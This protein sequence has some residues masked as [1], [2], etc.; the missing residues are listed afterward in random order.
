MAGGLAQKIAA[1]IP[2]AQFAVEAMKE[3]G[4][5]ISQDYSKSVTRDLLE[6]ADLVIT[7][8]KNLALE[9]RHRHPDMAR[10]RSGCTEGRD[11]A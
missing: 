5:D 9:L 4:I 1:A 11:R 7:V 8:E 2:V 3:V 10:V 6:W